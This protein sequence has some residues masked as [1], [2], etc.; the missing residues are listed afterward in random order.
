MKP[1]K[2]FKELLAC[3]VNLLPVPQDATSANITCKSVDTE[4]NAI[5]DI[6]IGVKSYFIKS[7]K[8]STTLPGDRVLVRLRDNLEY[9]EFF[10]E[11][12]EKDWL[13]TV[14]WHNRCGIY[15]CRDSQMKCDATFRE[16]TDTHATLAYVLKIHE[17]AEPEILKR[18]HDNSKMIFQDTIKRVLK[19]TKILTFSVK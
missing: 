4:D 13:S 8:W 1:E 7:S 9:D 17:L 11:D 2:L 5:E 3:G 15:N 10:A 18:F 14:F 19:L 16:G 12:Q 6:A